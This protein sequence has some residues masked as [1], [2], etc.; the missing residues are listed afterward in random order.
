MTYRDDP[1]DAQ[2]ARLTER[3]TALEKIIVEP[4][5]AAVQAERR[6]CLAH[7]KGMLWAYEGDPMKRGVAE[8]TGSVALA[9]SD[10]RTTPIKWKE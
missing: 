2:V 10:G 8:D 9:I 6:R 7:V 5:D 3:V 1:L 4:T